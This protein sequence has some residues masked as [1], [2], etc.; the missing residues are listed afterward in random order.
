MGFHETAVSD[1]EDGWLNERTKVLERVLE[2]GLGVQ[3][4]QVGGILKIW[5]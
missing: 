3:S 2:D 1:D 4:L 5:E